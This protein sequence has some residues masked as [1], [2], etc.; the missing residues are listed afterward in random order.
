MSLISFKDYKIEEIGEVY[1]GGTPKT[2]INEYWE[3]EIG[4]ITPKDLSN[5]D[6]IFI[7][8][9][10]RNITQK[11]LDNSS[12]KLVPKNTVLM[13]SRAPIGYLA[14]AE[15]ELST[16]QGFKSL[17]CDEDICYYKYFYYWLKLNIGYIIN[18][19]NGSTFK[20]ISGSTFK[21]LTISLPS[22][23]YQ[24]KISS[25]LWNID[26]KIENL[27]KINHN[28][29]EFIK[30]IFKYYFV[31]FI[32]FIKDL[33]N[34]IP[35]DW[36]SLNLGD[37][38]SEAN[39]GADAIKKAPIVNFDTG[40]K[41]VR[42]G[43]MTNSRRVDEWAFSEVSEE[44]YKK[45]QL[46]KDDIIVTRTATLGLNLLITEDLEAVYNNGLIRIK[47]DKN[48]VF[49]LFIYYYLNTSDYVHYIDSI[50][51]ESSTRPNM[52]INYLLKFPI[53]CPPMK[54]QEDFINIV[55]SL[56]NLKE[57]LFNQT[58]ELTK[59][60]DTLLPKLMSGEID[61]SKVNCD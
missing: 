40:I 19:S 39:T 3:G 48:K 34:G 16:N 15:N 59:L 20:E 2:S 61:V 52:K 29:E 51:G 13:T 50:E 26:E 35:K 44:N 58:V 7:S 25:I 56:F 49:P 12:A 37:V 41:C 46:K 42:V 21:N 33:E 27:K 54:I 8:H 9:G 23:E 57:K 55:E 18:N 24:K 6:N 28:L 31:D 43:D 22:L 38:V 45:Y 11:G 4:W 60:R 53:L 17:Y 36:E 47:L 10:E 32:P 30:S 5:Y 1:S 14:I